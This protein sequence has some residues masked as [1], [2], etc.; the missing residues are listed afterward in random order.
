MLLLIL[1][2][3][4]AL[5]VPHPA[6]LRSYHKFCDDFEKEKSKERFQIFSDNLIRIEAQNA[7]NSTWTAGI[8]QFTDWTPKEFADYVNKGL[9]V[10]RPK[11]DYTNWENREK[12]LNVAESID[13]TTKGAVTDVKNQGQCGSCWSFS[14]TGCLEGAMQI[15]TGTLDSFSEQE[16][17]DCDHTDNG[18]QGGLMDNGFRFVES[19]G[20]LCKESD[21]PYEAENSTCRKDSCTQVDIPIVSVIDVPSTNCASLMEALNLG[22]VSVAIEADKGV[23]QLYNGGVMD[24]PSCG[25]SLDHGVLAVGY[26]TDSASGKDY[27]KIKNSWG[28]SWGEDGYIRLGTQDI[29][30]V[31]NMASYVQLND[32]ACK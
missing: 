2:V 32:E 28:A 1:L 6:H 5:A 4:V 12:V 16:L 23:F 9:L 17:V 18:C 30:G 27:F 20:G 25:T 11:P 19:I 14:T 13:W 29:C 26:G 8:N 10:D 3:G 7:K 22:P 15:C 31:C 21:Y 24:D